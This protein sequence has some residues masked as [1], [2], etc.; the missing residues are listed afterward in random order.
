MIQ[1][2]LVLNYPDTYIFQRWHGTL[3]LYVV[4][5]VAAGFNTF[6][7]R[8]LPWIEG[9]ILIIHV[10][11]FFIV[12]IAVSYLG[13]HGT[14]GDVFTQFLTLGGYTPGASFFVG[15]ITSV[16]AF[17]GAD[18]A[19]HMSE[20]VKDAR[21]AVPKSLMAS[22]AL[23]GILGL[24]ILITTLFCIGDIDAALT[25]PTGF[26]FMEVFSQ[27]LQSTRFAT[28]LTSMILCLLIFACVAVL[29]ATS[30]VTWALARDDGIF[31]SSY[32]KRVDPRTQ[33]PLWAIGFSVLVTLLLGLINIGSSAAFNAVIS[34]VVAAYFG[35]Y[36][37]PISLLAWRR[38]KGDPPVFGPWNLGRYGLFV[39]V[40]AL[41]LIVIIFVFSFF[42]VTLPVTL[43]SMNWAVVL[44]A[45]SMICG[46]GFYFK[47]RKVF[48]GP[49]IPGRTRESVH[50]D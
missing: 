44:W 26:P 39:N 36:F 5:F 38:I 40:V 18:G 15:L 28:G 17:L 33:L 13:P 3:L 49:S 34:L 6:L 4:I 7:A 45:G 16:F 43:T 47:Q 19:I 21:N 8:L 11:G 25:T 35:S 23:N 29:A 32:L 48:S 46:V 50:K 24:A 27:A 2:L 1:G 12:L 22:I 14:A 20:E 30:R 31:F 41:V 10:V 42:P 37:I 9:S